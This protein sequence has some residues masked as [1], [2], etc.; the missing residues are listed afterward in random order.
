MSFSGDIVP[1]L[2]NSCGT[3]NSCHG[4]SNTSGVDLTTYNGV[5][6]TVLNHQLYSSITF[7]GSVNPMPKGASSPISNCSITTIKKWIDAGYPNN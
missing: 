3:T 2:N 7:D 4:T 1:I 5:K 6:T